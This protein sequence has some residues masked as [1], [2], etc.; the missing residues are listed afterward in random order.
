[1]VHE[2]LSDPAAHVLKKRVIMDFPK[3]TRT[4]VA[5]GGVDEPLGDIIVMAFKGWELAHGET[6]D[7]LDAFTTIS[8]ATVECVVEVSDRFRES[9][10]AR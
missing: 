6:L 8:W 2:E 10:N 9:L 7:R 4:Y 5:R 1:M 3:G